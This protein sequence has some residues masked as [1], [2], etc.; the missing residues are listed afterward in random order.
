[1]KTKIRDVLR[2]NFDPLSTGEIAAAT[3][4]SLRSVHAELGQNVKRGN[5]ARAGVRPGNG[6]PPAQLWIW[7][8]A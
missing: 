6:S 7:V 3:E 1:M 2:S 5:V 8:G 4:R